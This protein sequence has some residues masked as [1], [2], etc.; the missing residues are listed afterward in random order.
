MLPPKPREP[1]YQ[2]HSHHQP[3]ERGARRSHRP[4][5]GRKTWS[6]VQAPRGHGRK[7]QN[8]RKQTFMGTVR[9]CSVKRQGPASSRG[10]RGPC[11]VDTRPRRRDGTNRSLFH[12]RDERSMP[13]ALLGLWLP[14]TC[15]FTPRFTLLSEGLAHVVFSRPCGRQELQL[16][17]P[18]ARPSD[19]KTQQTAA[20]ALQTRPD[21]TRP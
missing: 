1:P 2:P 15:G 14:W 8:R 11:L 10:A 18:K 6:V 12:H 20:R 9:Q 13:G 16:L 19:L 7:E 17:Q 3:G 5:G 4:M 21:I